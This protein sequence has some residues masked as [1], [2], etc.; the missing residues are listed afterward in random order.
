MVKLNHVRIESRDSKEGKGQ[1]WL[2]VRSDRLE[3]AG[4]SLAKGVYFQ[5]PTS[6]VVQRASRSA[7]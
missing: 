3:E 2:A 6:F 5:L 7:R 1:S 4:S